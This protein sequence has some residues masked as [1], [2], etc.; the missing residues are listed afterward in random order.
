MTMGSHG[1]AACATSIFNRRDL[2]AMFALVSEDVIYFD[3][4]GIQ[5]GCEAIYK[6][7]YALLMPLADQ[8]EG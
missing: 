1:Y 6:R 4:I 5:A 7:E 2:E 3:G 8:S